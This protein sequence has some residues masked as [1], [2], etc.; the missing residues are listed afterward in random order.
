VHA[1]GSTW[2]RAPETDQEPHVT[3]RTRRYLATTAILA[4]LG[5]ATACSAEVDGDGASIE[6]DD[7]GISTD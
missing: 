7:D 1:A 6:V 5:G 2:D 3:V 4:L